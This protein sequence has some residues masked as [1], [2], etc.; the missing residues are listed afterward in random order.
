MPANL[1]AAVRSAFGVSGPAWPLPGGEGT[2]WQVGSVVLKPTVNPREASW[3]AELFAR[4]DGPGFRVPQPR[5]T[6][7]GGW[8]ADGWTAW[9]YLEGAPAPVRHWPELVAAS[10]AFHAALAGFP[11]PDWLHGRRDRWSVADRVAWHEERVAVAD[12]LQGLVDTLVAARRPVKLP[13]QLVHGDLA[14]NVLFADGQP[15]AV[16]DF[17]PYWRPAGYALAI[18]AVDVLTWW[19]AAPTILDTLDGEEHLDQLLLRA[20][21]FRLITESLGRPDRRSMQAVRDAAGPVVD[22]VVARVSGGALGQ[23]MDSRI[24]DHHPHAAR[25]HS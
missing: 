23:Q 1:T 8:L 24:G 3:C 11:R 16:I 25:P 7:D 10:R 13:N 17:S 9:E 22:L 15:P 18:A 6:I 20:L 21:L 2:T 4:L 12:A 5:R 14:G 19:G